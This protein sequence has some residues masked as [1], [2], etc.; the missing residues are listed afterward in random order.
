MRNLGDLRQQQNEVLSL[1]TFN[2]AGDHRQTSYSELLTKASPGVIADL[3]REGRIR[4]PRKGWFAPV[5]QVDLGLYVPK[6]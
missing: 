4:E 3:L 1:L 2:L 5:T 6:K